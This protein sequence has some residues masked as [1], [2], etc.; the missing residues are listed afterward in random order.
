MD[1]KGQCVDSSEI[2]V[3]STLFCSNLADQSEVLPKVP[4][5]LF[6]LDDTKS[7]YKAAKNGM[8]CHPQTLL[9]QPS[10]F[11]RDEHLDDFVYFEDTVG[12]LKS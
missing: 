3:Y 11:Y 10:R 5:L 8:L 1:M 7:Q 12:A 4:Q 2:C 6:R 9:Q